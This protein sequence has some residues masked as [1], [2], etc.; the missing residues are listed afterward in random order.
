MGKYSLSVWFGR[1]GGGRLF[2]LFQVSSIN[3]KPWQKP[4]DLGVL[5]LTAD[6]IRVGK[7]LK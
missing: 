7:P 4:V 6:P 1:V 2:D 5:Q 3:E